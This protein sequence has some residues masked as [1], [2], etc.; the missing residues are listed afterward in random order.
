MRRN[1]PPP[2]HEDVLRWLADYM[3]SNGYPP[4]RREM[5]EHFGMGLSTV[6]ETLA[7]LVDEGLL[8]VTPRIPRAMRITEGGMKLASNPMTEFS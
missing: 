6:Q 5:A 1:S 4:S 2:D 3:A 8:A 7:D